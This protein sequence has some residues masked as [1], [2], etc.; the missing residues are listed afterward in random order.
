MQYMGV[1]ED[2]GIRFLGMITVKTKECVETEL[3]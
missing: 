1:I 3:S 2:L